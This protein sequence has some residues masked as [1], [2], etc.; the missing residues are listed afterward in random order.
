VRAA[1][2]GGEEVAKIIVVD[3]AAWNKYVAAYNEAQAAGD[4]YLIR[5]LNEEQALHQAR[6]AQGGKPKKR[7]RKEE[8]MSW[9]IPSW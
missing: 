4:G 2:K 1:P 5:R 6:I 8:R 3:I 9:D 7:E